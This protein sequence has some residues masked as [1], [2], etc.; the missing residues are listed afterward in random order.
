MGLWI[1]EHT[2]HRK[3]DSCVD[4]CCEQA[5]FWHNLMCDESFFYHNGTH[6][7]VIQFFISFFF[8]FFALFSFV[9]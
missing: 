7:V 4:Y 2:T 5:Y 6:L 1:V 9:R 8:E 3:V